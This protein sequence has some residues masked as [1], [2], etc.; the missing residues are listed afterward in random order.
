MKARSRKEKDDPLAGA[1]EVLRTALPSRLESRHGA[2]E[3][4]LEALRAAGCRLDPF[5]DRLAIDEAITNAIVHGNR[6]DSERLVTVCAFA[7]PKAFGVE[8]ADEGEGFAWSEVVER[9]KRPSGAALTSPGGRG[10]PL[11][12]QAGDDIRFLDGGKRIVIA[13]KRG[14]ESSED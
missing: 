11:I 7:G 2:I 12:L 10:I 14:R 8:V 13:W 3:E 4:V 9:A 1:K 5:L 6:S